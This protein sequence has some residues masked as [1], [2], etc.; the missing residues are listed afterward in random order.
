MNE[1]PSSK[2]TPHAPPVAPTY[3]DDDQVHSL[4]VLGKAGSSIAGAELV[5]STRVSSSATAGSLQSLKPPS[6][7]SEQWAIAA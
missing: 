2:S 7:K 6:S 3:A 5:G 1:L 4:G